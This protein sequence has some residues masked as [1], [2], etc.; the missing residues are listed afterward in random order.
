M[1]MIDYLETGNLPQDKKQARELVLS[2]ELFTME[3]DVLYHVERDKSLRFVLP[4]SDRQKLFDEAHSGKFAGHLREAKIHS[5]LARHYWWPGMRVDITS[6]CRACLPCATRSVGKSIRPPLTPIPVGGPCDRVGVDVLQLPKTSHGN[7]YAVVFVDYFTKWP[8]V[9]ATRDQSAPTIAKLLVEEVI[10]R[11]GVP[12]QLV[13]DRGASFLSRLMLE[14]CSVMGI[15]KINTSAYHPQTDGLVERFNRTLT[16]ML[17]K[18]VAPGVE[19][20]DRLPYVLFAYRVTQQ[21]STGE[22]PFFLLYGH[23]PQ[24][25]SEVAFTPPVNREN[26]HLDDYKSSMLRAMREAWE[27]AQRTLEKAQKRQKHQHDKNARNAEF[28]VGD[29]GFTFMLG[30]S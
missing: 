2:K 9:Y 4:S 11:H 13:S 8:E 15:K 12:R 23:D 5:E 16:D 24:L 7:R 6:W 22:S 14:V 26:V 3:D 21:A 30:L 28:Q 17:A 27:L 1:P 25:P 19:W 20:D 29:R 18:T 10:S